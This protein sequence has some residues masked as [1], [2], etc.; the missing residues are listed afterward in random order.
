MSA[1]LAN[2]SP[3]QPDD[4]I[5]GRCTTGNALAGFPARDWIAYPQSRDAVEGRGLF[6]SIERSRSVYPG[7]EDAF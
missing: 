6:F 1:S 5:V 4:V 3:V 7:S 2:L